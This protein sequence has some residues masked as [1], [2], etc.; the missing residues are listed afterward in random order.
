MEK[1]GEI[2]LSTL[3]GTLA[4]PSFLLASL[5]LGSQAF[6]SHFAGHR[7]WDGFGTGAGLGRAGPGWAIAVAGLAAAARSVWRAWEATV[8]SFKNCIATG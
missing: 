3:V 6:S 5:P 8:M 4:L 7:G 2:N 1:F